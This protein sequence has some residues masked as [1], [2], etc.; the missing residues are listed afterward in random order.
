MRKKDFA[1]FNTLMAQ[2][3]PTDHRRK[4]QQSQINNLKD[5]YYRLV[6]LGSNNC[7]LVLE[8]NNEILLAL[9]KYNQARL[10]DE[11]NI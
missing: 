1:I 6:S 9:S 8:K 3:S 11:A 10:E 5:H 2:S 4:Q 7:I